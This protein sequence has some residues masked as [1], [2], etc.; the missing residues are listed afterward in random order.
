VFICASRKSRTEQTAASISLLRIHRAEHR[1]HSSFSEL[2]T[3]R[4]LHMLDDLSAYHAWT[5]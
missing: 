2:P 4:C 1:T 3:H 5:V